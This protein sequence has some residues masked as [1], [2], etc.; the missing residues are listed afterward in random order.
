MWFW[1]IDVVY[2]V[3]MMRDMW[4]RWVVVFIKKK[5]VFSVIIK[6][7]IGKMNKGSK[8]LKKL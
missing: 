5:F 7:I 8:I 4:I 1:E 6:V 3:L 2:L